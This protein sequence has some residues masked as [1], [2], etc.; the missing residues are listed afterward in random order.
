MNATVN[1]ICYKSK[2]LK[3]NESPLM[4][5]VCKD[6]KRKYIS[7]GIS[8]NPAYW[9]FNRNAPKPQCPNKEYIDSLIAQKVQEYSAQIIELKSMD[10]DFTATSL[11]EKVSKPNKVKTVGE[12]FVEQMNLLKQAQKL[13]Y[14]LSIQQTYNSLLEFNKHLNIYFVDIDVSWLKRYEAWLRKQG[15]AS[16]T[17]KGKFVDIRTMYNIAI[18]ENIVKVEHYPF[19]KF[20]IAKLQQETA[21]RAISKEDITRIIEYKTDNPLVQFAIDIFTFSYIMG[22]INFVDI[23]TLTKENMMDNRLVYIR[24]KTKK[25]IQLPL[26]DKAIELIEKYHDDGNPYLFP[27]LKAYHKTE[28]QKFNRVHKII[29]NVNNRLKKIGKDLEIPVTLT[30]YVARH[31]HATVLKKAGV[32]TS[33][34]SESLGH[35]SEK[36]TQVYLDSFGNEQMDEAMKN[37]L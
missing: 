8:V 18:D 36:I 35:S 9:D 31:S 34:I 3:N 24:H 27:I 6:R 4:V 30:T 15:L 25:L 5:R 21:K 26:Q 10:R 29:S 2:V 12:V 14:M 28:Q 17:I 37:L 1:V 16:N 32:A 19:R 33:I 13:S 23:S 20:K 22:G 7:L 11:V